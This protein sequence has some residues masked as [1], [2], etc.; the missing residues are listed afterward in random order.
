MSGR[1]VKV[2]CRMKPADSFAHA[3]FAGD[4]AAERFAV[5]DDVLR[6]ETFF[7]EPLIR[8][9]GVEIGSFF[10]RTA[11]AQAVAAVVHR[12]HIRAESEERLIQAEAMAD[13]A[14]VAVAIEK[15]ELCARGVRCGG[16]EPAVKFEAV[17]GFKKDVVEGT[18][19][20]SACGF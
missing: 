12:E 16:E 13:V 10:T 1:L 8:G 20:L 15:H 2:L 9:L 5:D 19:E 17:A 18:A 11:L 6:S 4:A 14:A 7:A 3:Q